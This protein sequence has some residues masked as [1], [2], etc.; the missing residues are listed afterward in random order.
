[1]TGRLGA[2]GEG[3]RPWLGRGEI[4][5]GAFTAA[6]MA[7]AAGLSVAGG[8]WEFAFYIAVMLALIGVVAALHWRVRLSLGVLWCLSV[9]GLMH[10]AGGLVPVEGVG[11]LYSLWLI[12]GWLRYDQLVHAYGFGVATVV[13]WEAVRARLRALGDARPTAGV[14]AL[15]VL[16]AM[17]LGAL[18]EVVEFAATEMMRETN[19]GDYRNNAKDL[20]FNAIGA[21]VVGGG[22]LGPGAIH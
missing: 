6:Y 13:C 18:N 20:V 11:V 4:A 10:M 7:A 5:V 14:V 2:D 22:D 21:V 12:P 17:G 9:W 1:M 16:G 19:V 8:S 3:R 15:C